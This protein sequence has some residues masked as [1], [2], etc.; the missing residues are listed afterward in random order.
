MRSKFLVT[1]ALVLGLLSACGDDAADDKPASATELKALLADVREEL[2]GAEA[3]DVGIATSRL[4]EGSTG[5]MSASGTAND[6]PAFKGTGSISRSGAVIN[7]DVI[8]IGGDVWANP[9]GSWMKLDP[10]RFGFPNPATIFGTKGDGILSILTSTD[11]LAE[12][13][14]ERSGQDVLRLVTGTIPGSVLVKFIPS[15]NAEG[16]FDVTYRLTE[17]GELVDASVE[18]PFYGGQKTVNYVVRIEA[19]DSPVTIKPPN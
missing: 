16:T 12:G 6:S 9:F 3:L 18:G 1:A 17:G 7:A 13:A 14:R 15:V 5:L 4:P 19:L 8:A 2:E 11:D 10:Q